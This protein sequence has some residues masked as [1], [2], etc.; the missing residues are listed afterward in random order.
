MTIMEIST[1]GT[2]VVGLIAW[3]VRL[4]SSTHATRD[5]L[6]DLMEKH[7]RLEEKYEA[8]ETRI[9]EKLSVIE[10]S[11]AKIEG[12]LSLFKQGE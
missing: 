10:K 6:K 1:V 2:S 9:V 8:M 7:I 3:L 12:R 11:L 5:R 4:E